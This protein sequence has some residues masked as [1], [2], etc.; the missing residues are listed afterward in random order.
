[1]SPTECN[2]CILLLDLLIMQQIIEDPL[3]YIL[4]KEQVFSN[5]NLHTYKQIHF[6]C[7]GLGFEYHQISNCVLC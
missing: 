1:M 2:V 3:C 5:F 7:F 6:S 4:V